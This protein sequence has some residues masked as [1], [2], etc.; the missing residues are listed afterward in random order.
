MTEKV[1]YIIIKLISGP[2]TL[3]MNHVLDIAKGETKVELPKIMPE[4]VQYNE[5]WNQKLIKILKHL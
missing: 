1:S 5:M 3:G 4:E 2:R